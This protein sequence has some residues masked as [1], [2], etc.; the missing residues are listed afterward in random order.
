MDTKINI[1][2]LEAGVNGVVELIVREGS[3][4]PPVP[5]PIPNVTTLEGNI[6]APYTYLLA[7]KE[8]FTPVKTLVLVND[9]ALSI[10]FK[11]DET[12]KLGHT[13]TGA[14]K[15]SRLLGEFNINEPGTFSD[16][17]LA[18]LLRRLPF[19]FAD[20]NEVD[21]M[22]G[23][24]MKFSA[25]V[26]TTIENNKSNDGS[27]KQLF[28]KKVTTDLPQT[29]TFDT[30]IFEGQD[31]VRFTALLC[32]EATISGVSF[33]FESPELYELEEK[34]KKRILAL[35]VQKFVE[36]GSAVIYI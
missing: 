4:L 32:A 16:K 26:Q 2:K 8:L 13:I 20:R 19:L 10:T 12:S 27:V 15:R 18:K 14:L 3:A 33:Y 7:K 34:E 9:K 21:K 6:E 35:N 28:E 23:S 29:L 11:T 36:Y 25:S 1:E 22:Y 30:P 24:L 31:S 5:V 17:N